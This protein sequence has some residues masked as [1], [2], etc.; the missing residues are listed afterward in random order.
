MQTKTGNDTAGKAQSQVRKNI[1]IR[2]LAGCQ[3]SELAVFLD[4]AFES[5]RHYASDNLETK[6]K[7]IADQMDLSKVVPCRKMHG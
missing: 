5:F 4:L 7:E 1:V 3:P 6:V 2:F